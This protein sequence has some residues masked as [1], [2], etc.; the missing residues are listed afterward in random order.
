MYQ[1]IPTAQG[2]PT[3]SVLFL[4]SLLQVY[5]ITGGSGCQVFIKLFSSSSFS[6]PYSL[7]FLSIPLYF[8]FGVNLF[9]LSTYIIPWLV[10]NVKG[11]LNYFLP[12]KKATQPPLQLSFQKRQQGRGLLTYTLDISEIQFCYFSKIPYHILDI[13]VPFSSLVWVYYCVHS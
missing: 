1:D 9:L 8:S 12:S 6:T 2:W 11:L 5:Y 7:R 4:Y 3:L 13:Q 10:S